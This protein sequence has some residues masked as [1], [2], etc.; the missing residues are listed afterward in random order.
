M[1]NITAAFVTSWYDIFVNF[2]LSFT[3]ILLMVYCT[4]V[5]YS[6]KNNFN[7][8]LNILFFL[9]VVTVFLFFHNAGAFAGFLFL[10]EIISLFTIYILLNKI[11][12]D[13]LLFFT[14]RA[15]NMETI[16][17]T[18]VVFFFYS[19]KCF[20]NTTWFEFDNYYNYDTLL[21]NDF[22]TTSILF[23]NNKYCSVSI[24]SLFLIIFSCY[25]VFNLCMVS[26]PQPSI[27]Y[28]QNNAS[29]ILIKQLLEENNFMYF[30]NK[31]KLY[32]FK[33]IC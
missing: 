20:I 23:F 10:C 5:I 29:K 1:F 18:I 6:S 16:F 14:K 31:L 7:L 13:E 4:I 17:A 19:Y 26:K 8:F 21:T 30:K 11:Q 9:V 27:F 32:F 3:F 12:N 2:S 25:I 33:K 28:K 24:I 15:F 22:Y